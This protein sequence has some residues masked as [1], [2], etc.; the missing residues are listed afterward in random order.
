MQGPNVK[1]LIAHKMSLLAIPPGGG[2]KDGIEFLSSKEKIVQAAKGA[3]AWVEDSIAVIKT[4]PDNPFK[5]DEE[6]AGEILRRIDEE[7]KWKP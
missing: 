2:L 3:T 6:I 4:A 5:T 1:R 7:R